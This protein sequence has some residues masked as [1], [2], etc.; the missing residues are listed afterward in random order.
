MAKDPKTSTLPLLTIL[1]ILAIL[2]VI[3][4]FF[5]R[6]ELSFTFLG[7]KGD[8]SME[9]YLRVGPITATLANEDIIRFSV[10]IDCMDKKLKERLSGKDSKIRDRIVSI[11]TAPDTEELLKKQ[12]YDEIKT[13][14][15]KSLDGISSEP[16]GDIYFADIIIY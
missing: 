9:N 4:I 11:I 16:I 6:Q 14:I 7:G 3:T 10:D 12:R 8:A 2:M 13:K 1:A 15:K 5:K